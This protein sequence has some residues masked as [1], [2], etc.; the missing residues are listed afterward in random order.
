MVTYYQIIRPLIKKAF[1]LLYA[2]ALRVLSCLFFWIW[3]KA[4]N[5]ESINKILLVKMERIGDLVLSTPPI[6][7]VREHFP[8]S[9]ISIIA[10]PSTKQIIE[11]DPHLNEVIVY[12]VKGIH[13]S[14]GQKIRF[15]RNLRSREFDLG[16]DLT[17]RDFFF[18]PV[19]LLYLSGTKITLGLD[20]FGRG[21]LFNIKVK[22]YRQPKPLTEEVLYILSPFGIDTSDIKPKLFVS[23]EDKDYIQQYLNREDINKKDLL[24]AIHPGGYY[25]TQRWRKDGYANVAQHLI[26][27]YSARVFFVG[28]RKE[29][30]LVNEIIALTADKPIN[31]A[32]KISLGQ[33]MALISRCQLFIGN[34]S[35]PLHI[36]AG[37]NVPTISFLGPAI[38]ERWQPQGKKNIVFRKDL[39]CSPCELGYCWRKDFTCMREIT[40]E[41][42]IEAVDRQLQIARR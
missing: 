21:F 15:I 13:R 22:S 16:I 11:N 40:P 31:L 9:H 35:G 36:A 42:V 10:D 37:L 4:L 32:G 1:Y 19:W 26:K 18:T 17:T 8:H 41:E 14:P 30:A 6:R 33:L 28:S 2:G 3:P 25:E 34:S 5:P 24:I 39:P 29:K 12:D 27:K 38:P 23:N 20:N 7:A